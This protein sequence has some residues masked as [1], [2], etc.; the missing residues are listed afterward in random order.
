M[1]NNADH[2]PDQ[3]KLALGYHKDQVKVANFAL[4]AFLLV[5]VG[6][7]LYRVLIE[8]R[9]TESLRS[10]EEIQRSLDEAKRVDQGLIVKQTLLYFVQGRDSSGNPISPKRIRRDVGQ[11]PKQED[12]DNVDN[13]LSRQS[14]TSIRSR[15][16]ASRTGVS[17]VHQQYSPFFKECRFEVKE[18]KLLIQINLPSEFMSQGQAQLALRVFSESPADIYRLFCESDSLR[19]RTLVSQAGEAKLREFQSL[20][21][22]LPQDAGGQQRGKSPG[23]DQCRVAQSVTRVLSELTNS[24]WYPG[25]GREAAQYLDGQCQTNQ[26]YLED[27]SAA[28]RYVLAL[29]TAPLSRLSD[30]EAPLR[31]TEIRDLQS[32][33]DYSA[34]QQLLKDA[35]S[36][37]SEA[38]KSKIQSLQAEMLKDR[39]NYERLRNLRPIRQDDKGAAESFS[40]YQLLLGALFV[41]SA[42]T[43]ALTA[44][45]VSRSHSFEVVEIERYLRSKVD[46]NMPRATNPF[47][48]EPK[49]ST[50][51]T[52]IRELLSLL[53]SSSTATNPKVP[54]EKG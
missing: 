51:M 36:K 54:A 26:N 44:A 15:L 40:L 6:F 50:D 19:S 49:Q 45:L 5:L 53:K 1:S 21:D 9:L 2:A 14:T 17:D 48:R 20:H 34:L 35:S 47:A 27:A 13:I 30:S 39:G 4:I 37:P 25:F 29:R 3:A 22:S 10:S 28:L 16:S 33:V 12:L 42:L 7:T 32:K 18:E 8:W 41:F 11:Q 38:E 46:S 24:D 52:P 43:A 31:Q 23:S